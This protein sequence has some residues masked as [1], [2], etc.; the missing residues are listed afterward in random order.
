MRRREVILLVA[1]AV[2]WPSASRAQA[3]RVY[4]VGY[5]GT[6]A[7]NPRNLRFFHDGLRE[8]GWIEGQNITIQYKFGEGRAD[9]LP[10]LA[11]EL[12]GLKVDIIVA[13]PT[14]AT[15]AA[16]NATQSIPIV[17]IGFDNPVQHGLIASLARPGGN[18]TGVTYAVGPEIFGKDIE[19]LLELVPALR[20][21]AILSN[22]DGP[23]H[24]ITVGNVET[25]ARSLKLMPLLIE[26]RRPEELDTAFATIA[27]KQAEAVLVVGDPLYGVHQSRLSELLQRYR[28]P[29]VHT[30]RQQ[31]EAGGL[32]S[33]GPS[34]PE[35]WRR[36][37][38][39]VDKILK[40][41]KPADLPVE[42]PTKYELII[43]LR[44]ARGLS[45]EVPPSLLARADEVIE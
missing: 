35:L 18:V 40:G 42:Q 24:G 38:A 43:N 2:A 15:L 8:H 16:R 33:Y 37:A 27:A 41:T 21:V 36:G 13:S 7:S 29:A 20:T 3:T 23:N 14:P 45:L 39:Y 26:V 1:G 25:A 9:T 4:R 28:L 10:G 30:N 34:F 11:A 22:P 31:V 12:I 5:L 17:G 6:G 32:M 19:L 44:T